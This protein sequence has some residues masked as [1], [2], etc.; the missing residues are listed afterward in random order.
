[1]CTGDTQVAQ[2]VPPHSTSGPLFLNANGPTKPVC[3][4]ARCPENKRLF[5]SVCRLLFGSEAM[6]EVTDSF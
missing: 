3:P 1:M 5:Q 4:A 6:T 2:L